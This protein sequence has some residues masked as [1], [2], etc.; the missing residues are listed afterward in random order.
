MQAATA[1]LTRT[2]RICHS[3]GQD[4]KLRTPTYTL[5]H[6]HTQ[7]KCKQM[8]G[9]ESPGPGQ[10]GQRGQPASHSQPFANIQIAKSQT[11]SH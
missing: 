10:P 9:R 6:L 1:A 3:W 2:R 7:G 4:N 5:T 8:C 11:Y